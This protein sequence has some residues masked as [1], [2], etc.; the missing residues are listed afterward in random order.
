MKLQKYDVKTNKVLIG[1]LQSHID[2][3]ITLEQAFFE[4]NPDLKF[5][6]TISESD[7][8]T[9]K[10]EQKIKNI[11][12][13]WDQF[14]TN[15][16]LYGIRTEFDESFY[17]TP[18]NRDSEFYKA[19]VEE[20][21]RI[22]REILLEKSSRKKEHFDDESKYSAV[23]DRKFKGRKTRREKISENNLDAG[24]LPL[25]DPT[26][27]KNEENTDMIPKSTNLKVKERE[28]HS[29][30][31]DKE[32]GHTK[33]KYR[34]ECY[35]EIKDR[36]EYHVKIKDNTNLKV[37]NKEEGCLEIKESINSK[38]GDRECKF[39]TKDIEWHA[40]I[41]DNDESLFLKVKD[42]ENHL[43]IKDSVNMKA[44]DKEESY[45]K[46]KDN[47]YMKAKGKDDSTRQPI[48]SKHSG[49]VRKQGSLKK[50]EKG[51]IARTSSN[52]KQ[53]SG[54]KHAHGPTNLRPHQTVI[55]DAGN[56][57]DYTKK[58]LNLNM[59]SDVNPNINKDVNLNPKLSNKT[60]EKLDEHTKLD[61][62]LKINMRVSDVTTGLEHSHVEHPIVQSKN[63]IKEGPTLFTDRTGTEINIP[64]EKQE[65]KEITTRQSLTESISKITDKFK[66][67]VKETK[68][69]NAK[70]F[71][72]FITG[73]EDFCTFFRK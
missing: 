60:Y 7:I 22:E 30:V 12:K 3:E 57:I 44:K 15:E 69:G 21:K 27:R 14:K 71:L 37:R 46:V 19:N 5:R 25:T 53:R 33:I 68:W 6:I 58:Q 64:V 36:E 26:V 49:S 32:E 48:N 50:A 59:R 29:K 61:E 38:A 28:G 1:I 18:I 39:K 2:G 73:R 42:K 72:S 65:N 8:L 23:I 66:G 51:R 56:L 11:S 43:K 41:K 13:K 67:A 9:Q 70:S 54:I 20:A 31:K 45:L 63:E 10:I 55:A 4:D 40:K 52:I 35:S 24:W 34:E 62:N 16:E 47:A 17:T